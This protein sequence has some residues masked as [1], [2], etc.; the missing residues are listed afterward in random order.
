MLT[1]RDILT[2][3][4]ITVSPETAVAEAARLMESH[5][6]NGLPVM[7]SEG[8]LAGVITQSD[9]IQQC[10]DLEL[11]PALNIFDLH[12]FLEMPSHFQARMEKMLGSTVGEVMTADPLTIEPE[13]LVSEIA[14]LMDR[15][16]VHTLPV[17]DQGKLLGVVG[18]IDLIRGL[19]RQAPK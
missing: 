6:L 2:A 4:V 19:A 5:R 8:R 14:A 17:L 18:K 12:L 7:D 9:L 1:A 3:E 10:R 13:M 16:Q 11:P 15:E